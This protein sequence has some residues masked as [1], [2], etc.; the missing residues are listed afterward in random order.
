MNRIGF[1]LL[2]IALLFY[3]TVIGLIGL[4]TEDS[5]EY[6]TFSRFIFGDSDFSYTFIIFISVSAFMAVIILIL[7]LLKINHSM[8]NS[9]LTFYAFGWLSFVLIMDI[10][11]PFFNKVN[12]LEFFKSFAI[13]LIFQGAMF[14]VIKNDKGVKNV[15]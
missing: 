10:I 5:G 6:G 9:G 14:T 4:I 7:K 12:L 2:N 1:I 8:L 15:Q 13:H 3:L 11:Y